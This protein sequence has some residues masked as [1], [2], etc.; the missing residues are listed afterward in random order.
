MSLPLTIAPFT[1]NSI[2]VITCLSPLLDFDLGNRTVLYSFYFLKKY[3][4]LLAQYLATMGCP[5]SEQV[6]KEIDA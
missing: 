2:Y 1:V 4:Q 6:L 3:P 5:Q